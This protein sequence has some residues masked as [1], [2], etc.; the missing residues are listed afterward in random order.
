MRKGSIIRGVGI[1][2]AGLA[3][4]AFV[5]K[6]ALAEQPVGITR[7]PRVDVQRPHAPHV[8]HKPGAVQRPHLNDH[9][10]HVVRNIVA[11]PSTVQVHIHKNVHV[12]PITHVRPPR[13]THT[14][15]VVQVN[16]VKTIKKH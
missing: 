3:V 1:A 10:P 4:T 13:K 12:V 2:V 7:A 6:A 5:G 11:S 9:P 8:A 15:I 14:V 16:D